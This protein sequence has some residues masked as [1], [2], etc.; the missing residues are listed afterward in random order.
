MSRWNKQQ[1]TGWA[2]VNKNRCTWGKRTSKRHRL[3]LDR[4]YE[5]HIREGLQEDGRSSMFRTIIVGL[6]AGK[7]LAMNFSNMLPVCYYDYRVSSN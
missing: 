4:G 6:P 1:D 2:R 7:K 5:G 3:T